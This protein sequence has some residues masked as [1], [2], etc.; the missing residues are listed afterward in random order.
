MSNLDLDSVVVPTTNE[1]LLIS[2]DHVRFN[3]SRTNVQMSKLIRVVLET[4]AEENMICF[5]EISGSVLSRVIEYMNHHEGRTV[6]PL[7]PRIFEDPWDYLFIHRVMDSLDDM[8]EIICAASYL[9]MDGLLHLACS[10]I[11]THIESQN[12]LSNHI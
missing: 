3:V 1:V 2:Q 12:V 6:L 11:A 5:G 9:D 4:D 7:G 8:Y 10:Q